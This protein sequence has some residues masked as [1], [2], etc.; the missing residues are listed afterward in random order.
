MRINFANA[1]TP[2]A[3]HLTPTDL[4]QLRRIAGLAQGM[5]DFDGPVTYY[6][7]DTS[8]YEVIADGAH[9]YD[10]WIVNGWLPLV[11]FAPGGTDVV[12]WWSDQDDST[13]GFDD[14]DDVYAAYEAVLAAREA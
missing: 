10:A 7:T 11:I 1:Y 2:D 5:P 12:A 4:A 13:D 3:D 14:G 6:L 9:R 8:R